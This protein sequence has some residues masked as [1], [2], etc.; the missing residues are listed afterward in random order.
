VEHSDSRLTDELPFTRAENVK[1][2]MYWWHFA[3]YTRTADITATSQ[4]Y[5]QK[6]SSG[7][8]KL[9]SLTLSDSTTDL[10]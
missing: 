2:K 10:V 6:Y 5:E 8:F 1:I 4:L 3:C 7:A 9:F